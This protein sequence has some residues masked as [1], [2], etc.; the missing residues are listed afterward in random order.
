M[1]DGMKRYQPISS[2]DSLLPILSKISMFGG[3]DEEKL[4]LFSGFLETAVFARGETIF[5]KGDEPTH[6][7]IVKSGRVDLDISDG[8]VVVEK[9]KLG[10]GESFGEASLIAMH[11]HTATAIADEESEIV[12]LS[13]HALIRLQQKDTMTFALLVMNIARDLARRLKLTD[14]ILLHYL[15]HPDRGDK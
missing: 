12:V 7:Y 14:D 15:H 9:A 13:R 3:I 8:E 5:Q 4:R 10:V 1:S 11:K 2:I 6:I